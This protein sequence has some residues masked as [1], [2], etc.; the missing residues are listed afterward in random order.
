MA[1]PKKQVVVEPEPAITNQPEIKHSLPIALTA[2]S[3][4]R[5]MV[6]GLHPSQ[7]AMQ[8]TEIKNSIEILLEYAVTT[9]EKEIA[10]QTEEEAKLA[11]G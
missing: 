7:M 8:S 6:A 3:R 5:A 1:R 2:I 4:V 11:F 9:L 10:W